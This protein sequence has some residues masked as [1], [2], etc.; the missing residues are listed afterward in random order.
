M[1]VETHWICDWCGKI[2][3]ELRSDDEW[4]ENHFCCIEH[5]NKYDAH[6][7]EGEKQ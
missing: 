4:C 1:R 5:G 6:E 2:L 3:T 7:K